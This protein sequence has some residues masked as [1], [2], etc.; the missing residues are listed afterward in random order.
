MAGVVV[1]GEE[2]EEVEEWGEIVC[3]MRNL[4]DEAVKDWRADRNSGRRRCMEVRSVMSRAAIITALSWRFHRLRTR[5]I[6]DYARHCASD[7]PLLVLCTSHLY[8]HVEAV[9]W[10]RQRYIITSRYR[11]PSLRKS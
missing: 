8:A 2:K 9:G 7:K 10:S 5:D 4:E 11:F 3:R 6:R 1:E